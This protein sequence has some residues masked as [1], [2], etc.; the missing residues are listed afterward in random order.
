M[1]QFRKILWSTKSTAHK[2]NG[3]WSFMLEI[4]SLSF[5]ADFLVVADFPKRLVERA[6]IVFFPFQR[7]NTALRVGRVDMSNV[8]LSFKNYSGIFFFHRKM[9]VIHV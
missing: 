5:N 3:L 9:V 6:V 8:L 4:F 7:E 1:Y 2:S